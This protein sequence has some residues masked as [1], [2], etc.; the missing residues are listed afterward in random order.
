MCTE[1]ILLHGSGDGLLLRG[2]FELESYDVMLPFGESS[3]GPS[4]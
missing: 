1:S 4:R 3:S 2:S